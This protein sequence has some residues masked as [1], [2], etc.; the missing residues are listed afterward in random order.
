MVTKEHIWFNY[1]CSEL[2]L[3]VNVLALTSCNNR[4]S[5][6]YQLIPGGL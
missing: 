5:S 4:D 1:E 2:L 6:W 3:G